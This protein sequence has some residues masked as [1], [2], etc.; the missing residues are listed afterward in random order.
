[1][2]KLIYTIVAFAGILLIANCSPKTTKNATT[3]NSKPK[4]EIMEEP[5]VASSSDFKNMPLDAQMDL[6]NSC[7]SAKLEKGQ[8]IYQSSC[9]KCHELYNPA[10]RTT[11]SWLKIMRKMG[12]KAKLENADYA[13]VSA[14]LHSKAKQ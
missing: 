5:K 6:M 1:M 9:G 2:N 13:L 8:Q 7:G 12:P 4:E 3:S 10:M 11:E 14:Y